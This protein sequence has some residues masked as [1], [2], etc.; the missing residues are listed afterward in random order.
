MHKIRK[1]GKMSETKRY[2]VTAALPYANGPLH[3]G[4]LAGAYLSGD[5]YVRHLR[6]LGKDVAFV[7]GS[8][9]HGAA[10]T[11]RAKKEGTTPQAIIDQNHQIIKDSFQKLGVS[12]DIYHRTSS[13]LHHETA[14]EMFMD[15]YKK[16]V[17]EEVTNEQYYDE[18]FNQFLADRYITGTCPIC[19]NTEAYGDQCESCG[20]ALS[21]LELKDPKS[22]LSGKSPILKTTTHWYLPLN[23]EED[24]LKDWIVEGKGR[25][26][27]WKKNVLGQAKS[28]LDAGLQPRAITRDLDWG[29]PVPAEGGDGKVLYV[30]FDAPIGYIS[31]T[32]QWAQDNGK[33]WKDYWQ[34][35]DS[36]LIHF[37]GKDNI[38]FHTIIFPSMLKLS[39]DYI[40]PTN[41]PANEFMNLEGKKLSTSRNWAVWAHEY[42]EDLPGK[43]DEL[44]HTLIKYMPET[45]DSEFNWASYKE[46]VDSDLVGNLAN[47]INR[48]VVLTNKYFDGKVPAF[49]A[50]AVVKDSKGEASTVG[51]EMN[52][53]EGKLKE[54]SEYISQYS[55]R[56]A[57]QT[58]LEISTIGNQFLQTNEPWK[59]FKTNPE[60]VE[61]VMNVALQ[62]ITALSVVSR[63]FIPFASDKIRTLLGLAA[64]TETGELQELFDKLSNNQPIIIANHQIGK[65][66]HLFTRIPNEVVESQIEKLEKSQ[67]TTIE[68]EKVKKNIDFEDFMK[69]DLRTGTIIEA[70]K[71]KKS[72][73]LLKLK[74]DLGFEQRIIVSGIAEFYK[75]EEVIGQEVVVVANLGAKKLRG[76][77]SEGMILMAEN[78]EGK[79]DFVSSSNGFG[80][81]FVVK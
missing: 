50:M 20:S 42:L 65:P 41:V 17:F 32:K 44:R 18:E 45:K 19:E 11:I 68:Y 71:V 56:N 62:I 28:W 1:R 30:W 66:L 5:I 36:K 53:L 63:P 40:L 43:E 59:V 48:V 38:V 57:Q 34:R 33:N 54:L 24:W 10:I 29:I 22:T 77:M 13:E 51:Q 70:E 74:V 55:F 8:D 76:V 79:L 80:N 21:P 6:L 64:M 69:I 12:F 3:I 27:A 4:H 9:E 78:N 7:C 49:D 37:L 23:K 52:V 16:G 14:S 46:A 39:G 35:D 47:F 15:L 2:L 72:K 73:K 67:P 58:L 25:T 61:P 26:E 75:A 31:A 60:A 81:G